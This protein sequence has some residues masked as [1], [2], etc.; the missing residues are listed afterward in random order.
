MLQLHLMTPEEFT[1]YKAWMVE[2]YAKNNA[3]NYRLLLEEARINSSKEIDG[4][5]NQGF[6]T[7]NQY[8]YNIILSGETENCYIGYL[9][10]DIDDQKKRCFVADIYINPDN[11]HQGW[12]RKTL[13]L[14]DLNMKQ[15]GI[16]RIVLHVFGNNQ[17]AQELYKKMGYQVIGLN[18]QK[19]LND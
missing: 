16:T 2:D 8:L 14:L 3:E 10:V 19:W 9:W 17:I 1:A 12:G 13:E 15:R 18:M 5:I 11:R 4:L 6:S 7:P